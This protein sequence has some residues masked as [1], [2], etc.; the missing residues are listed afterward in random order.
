MRNTD[1]PSIIRNKK[2]LIR[3][4]S[5]RS[6]ILS[7]IEDNMFG[8]TPDIVFDRTQCT[9]TGTESCPDAVRETYLLR[10]FKGS[11]CASMS[12]SVM[13]DSASEAGKAAP[14]ILN[15]NPFSR[16]AGILSNPKYSFCSGG[17]FPALL[18]VKHGFAAVQCNADEFSSDSPDKGPDDIMTLFPPQ[19]TNG[20]CTID[21]WAFAGALVAQR[22]RE[23]GFTS[24]SICVSGFSRG[25]RTALWAAAKYKIF[26]SVYACQA[27]CC[28]SAIHRG[29][30]GE[31]ISDITRR[32]PQ[33]SC[34]KL[35]QYA[36]HEEE[37][38]FDQHMMLSLIFPRP[39]YISSAR[40][41]SWSCPEK[42]FEACVLL[43][44]FHEEMGYRGLESKVYPSDSRTVEGELLAYH[45][46]DGGHD[47]TV[48]DWEKVIR[49]LKK[50]GKDK[51]Q[52]GQRNNT[53]DCGHKD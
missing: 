27:G 30:T 34:N 48:E 37:L 29:K 47:C 5:R 32:Y 14:V 26:T 3:W 12:F 39:L 1:L 7:L 46:K 22:L 31:T 36:G 53:E 18:L 50:S 6:E 45:V 23:L 44:A 42:E 49:F 20:W 35:K 2:D 43:S 15:I 51:G 40:E 21:A 33:W 16:N 19:G 52:Q 11:S 25:A 8:R 9:L 13:Y 17:V 24:D 28:G 38:P 4:D 10:V 41:D